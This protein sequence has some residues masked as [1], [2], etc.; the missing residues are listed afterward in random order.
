MDNFQLDGRCTCGAIRH[1]MCSGP[2]FVHCC[3][4]RWCQLES[5]ASF[6]LNA[7][8]EADRV[9]LLVGTPEIAVTSSQS[10]KGEKIAQGDY[11]CAPG[12]GHLDALYR[13][14]RHGTRGLGPLPPAY[15]RT[16]C[17][18]SSSAFNS[19]SRPVRALP[20]SVLI[21]ASAIGSIP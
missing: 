3:H 14:I 8:I 19:S 9:K 10:G 6:A 15:N 5:R 16:A 11:S 20:A 2:M 7:M 4:C 17:C 1:R 21:N 18:K 12:P 13:F